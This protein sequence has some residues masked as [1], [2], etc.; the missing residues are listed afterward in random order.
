M[1]NIPE[2]DFDISQAT[3]YIFESEL[4]KKAFEQPPFQNY[5]N[6]CRDV[7]RSLSRLANNCNMPEFTNHGLQHICSLVKR[8]SEWGIDAG[9]LALG[10]E[11]GASNGVEAL[12]PQEA[13][14]LLL[15]LLLHDIGMQQQDPKELLD[16]QTFNTQQG[17]ADVAGW[18]RR[19]H[20]ARLP[21][22][23]KN[24][25]KSYIENDRNTPSLMLHIDI[26]IHIAASHNY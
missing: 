26:I 3:Q 7:I 25:L 1:K 2:F 14:Y 4:A 13:G 12:C 9:W 6:I 21:K 19:T 22:L 5:A 24:L 10:N 18:V 16:G 15:A 17:F 23:V 11:K 20:V 8:A